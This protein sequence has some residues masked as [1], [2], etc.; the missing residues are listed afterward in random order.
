MAGFDENMVREYFELNGFLVRQLRK[1][2]VQSRSKRVDEQVDLV[3][4]NPSARAKDRPQGFQIFSTE[5]ARIPR[6]VVVVKGWHTSSFTPRMLRSGKSLFDF[7]QQDVIALVERYFGVHTD[8][9]S[10][11]D[12]KWGQLLKILVLPGLP[13]SDP[14]REES[15]ALLKEKGVDGIITFRTILENIVRQI[16]PNH[17]YRKSEFLHIV[18]LLKIYDMIRPP[19][20]ELF[21]D[22]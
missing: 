10:E 21:P 7:L 18:R 4:L 22:R 6:A 11:L 14:H 16:E 9:D 8:A 2:G 20:M 3:V 1:Y 13:P 5:L 19:Q 12:R 17:D 15:I